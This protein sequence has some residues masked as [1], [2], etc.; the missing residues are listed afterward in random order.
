[1]LQQYCLLQFFISNN[2]VYCSLKLSGDIPRLFNLVAWVT[3]RGFIWPPPLSWSSMSSWSGCLFRF[4]VSFSFS[5]SSMEGMKPPPYRW[6]GS[7]FWWVGVFCIREEDRHC[8]SSWHGGTC[9]FHSPFVL[10]DLAYHDPVPWVVAFI[11]GFTICQH[12]WALTLFPLPYVHVPFWGL[13]PHH[14]TWGLHLSSVIAPLDVH[15]W[16][17]TSCLSTPGKL[18]W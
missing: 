11:M 15:D 18:Y 8:H 4:P 17:L 16:S 7:F 1:M 6:Q 10:F 14:I 2:T 9:P 12:Q 5:L 3:L 13:Q